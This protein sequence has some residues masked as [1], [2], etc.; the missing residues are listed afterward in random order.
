MSVCR[1]CALPYTCKSGPGCCLRL[2]TCSAMSPPKNTEG[3]HSCDVMVCEATYLVAGLTPGHMSAWCGQNGAQ[4]SK[5]LRPNNRSNG[6]F[7]CLFRA[8]SATS[9]PYG[10]THPPYAKPPLVSSSGPP[11]AWMT[12]SRVMN[13]RAITFLMTAFLHQLVTSQ[14][15]V[16]LRWAFQ[17]HPAARIVRI[18]WLIPQNGN[19][20][21]DRRESNFSPG[22]KNNLPLRLS[23]HP[24]NDTPCFAQY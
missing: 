18:L 10:A 14:E 13:S 11:P 23:Q 20:N 8:V 6:V 16:I 3:C 21:N 9:S 22:L 2:L 15:A 7:I 4:I 1:R 12:P 5:V 24:E 17:S 19:D